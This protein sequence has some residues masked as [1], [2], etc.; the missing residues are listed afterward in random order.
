M[1][2]KINTATIIGLV[3]YKILVE[4]DTSMSLPSVVIVGLPDVAISEAKERVRSAVKNSG[5]QFPNKKVIV[6][7]APADLKKEG[8]NYDLPIA[9]GILAKEGY[10]SNDNFEEYAILGELSL[11]GEI[12][13]C[14]L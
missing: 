5:F 11:D 6:N 14:S 9:I 10:I 13:S 12:R 7:L 1:V 2:V 8:T 3:P 4:V